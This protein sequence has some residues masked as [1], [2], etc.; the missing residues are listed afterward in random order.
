MFNESRAF[1]DDV[2]GRPSRQLTV[3]GL[4]NQTPTYHLNTAF[5]ADS[6]YLV[7]A[8]AREGGS[9]IVKAEMSTGELTVLAVTDGIGAGSALQGFA[10]PWC[11]GSAGGGHNGN[12]MAVLQ[13]SNMVASVLGRSLRVYDL[14]TGAERIL[15]GDVGAAYR[16]GNPVGSIDG[17]H[18][19]VTRAPEHPDLVAGMPRAERGYFAACTATFGGMPTDYLKVDISTGAVEVIF[20]EDVY[21]NNHIQPCPADPELLL[22]DR[23]APPLF[24]HGSDGGKTTLCWTLDTRTNA[25]TEI[26]PRDENGFQIHTNWDRTG[27]RIYYHGRSAREGNPIFT[28]NGG[29]Y[30]GVADRSGATLWE[31]WF[32]VFNYGHVSTH[33]QADAII[34]DGLLTPDMVTAIHYTDLDA[35]GTPRIEILAR[36]NTLWDSVIGQYAHPHCHMSPDGRWLSYNRG[37]KGRTNLCV[38]QVG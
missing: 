38:V 20:H 11:A 28:P 23:D 32:P 14:D 12:G 6:R 34:T 1:S 30:I 4:Y 3:S 36:H 10:G 13:A 7:F 15:I 17:R 27:T 18:I 9:A 26:A 19:F 16:F 37:E 33:T 5:T 35:T 2:T 31:G 21:G 8:T 29:H 22:I 24:A 25:L